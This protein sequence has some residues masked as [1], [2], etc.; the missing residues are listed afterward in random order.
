MCLGEAISSHLLFAFN[1]MIPQKDS[2][3]LIIVRLDSEIS[4]ILLMLCPKNILVAENYHQEKIDYAST[5]TKIAQQNL[6]VF[7]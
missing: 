4:V 2:S 3:T 1:N 7:L 6:R 5:P